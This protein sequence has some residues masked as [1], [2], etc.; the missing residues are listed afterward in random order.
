MIRI[1]AVD[2]KG[3]KAIILCITEDSVERM[4]QGRPICI[5][6]AEL[7]FDGTIAI[8]LGGD[9]DS[10]IADLRTAGLIR[11]DTPIVRRDQGPT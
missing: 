5:D 4:R 3:R 9:N 8:I 10:M 2:E 7:G 11:P 6:A 1:A